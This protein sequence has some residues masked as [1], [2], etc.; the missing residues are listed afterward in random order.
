MGSA[1][2]I[3][4]GMREACYKAIRAANRAGIVVSYDPNLRAELLSPDLIAE[5]SEPV[6][7]V[8][9]V[10][11]P[12]RG[13]LIDLTRKRSTEEAVEA[14]LEKGVT[15]VVVKHGA[16]GSE[17]F[18]GGTSAF[19]PSYEVQEVDPTGAGDAFDAACMMGLLNKWPIHE[20]LRL[21]N[22]V[23]ALKVLNVGPMEVPRS[24]DEVVGFMRSA[25]QKE[26]GRAA[27]GGQGR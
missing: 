22:A 24:V 9:E 5:I 4:E 2:T 1:L 15:T 7:K 19:E 12:S 10:V 16:A 14:L 3:G 17:A 18:T 13:E 26:P 6:L 27:A 23:G 21:A 20:T 25:K 8:A 11:M